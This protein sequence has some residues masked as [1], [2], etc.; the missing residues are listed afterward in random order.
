MKCNNAKRN[1]SIFEIDG[2]SRDKLLRFCVRSPNISG[3]FCYNNF[4]V[5]T[6]IGY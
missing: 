1:H 5:V 6:C 4:D 2:C 3:L